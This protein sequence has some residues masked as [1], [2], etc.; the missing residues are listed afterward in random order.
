MK[1]IFFKK[2]GTLFLVTIL[3]LGMTACSKKEEK[4]TDASKFA[5]EYNSINGT[6]SS[7]G[8]E[9]RKLNISEDNPFIYATA[10]EIVEKINNKETF[11][12]YFGFNTCPWCRS[13]IE[14]LIRCAEDYNYKEIYYVDVKEI[15]DRIELDE[16][17][18]PKTTTEGS[19][20]YMELVD[21]LSEVLD[22]YTLTSSSGEEI[23][24][25]EKRIFAP[26]VI[27]IVDGEAKEK[28]DGISSKLEDPYSE[29]TKEMKEESYNSIK[30]IFTCLEKN[31]CK[32]NAC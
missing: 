7:S 23:S 15:R 16:N 3:L 9:Y 28:V 14:E 2:I 27:S 29:I 5:E 10:E 25:N 4:E 24:T 12:V 20:G 32:K 21:A 26:N 22:D 13:M 19:K 1:K 8:K 6:K 31:V 18:E 17:N 11:V 30:C